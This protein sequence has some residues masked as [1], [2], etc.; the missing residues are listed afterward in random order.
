M[1]FKVF[2]SHSVGPRELAIVYALAQEAAKRGIS[3]VIPDRMW[4]PQQG[5]P[6]RIVQQIKDCDDMV[7]FATQFG[8]HWDWVV[9]EVEVKGSAR[10]F[11][12]DGHFS[13]TGPA[14]SK[15][16]INRLDLTST[17]RQAAQRL[18]SMSLAKEQ[19]DALT[20]LVVGGLLFM[21]FSGGKE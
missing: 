6:E 9:K 11:I 20:W 18:E 12:S 1:A 4:Q 10:L 2:I 15:V 19:K 16:D 14:D 5:V 17:I 13:Y 21:L 3:P 8:Q 7:V